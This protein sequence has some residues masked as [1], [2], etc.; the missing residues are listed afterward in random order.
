M[1]TPK[2][3]YW[4][5]LQQQLS[6]AG[7]NISVSPNMSQIV[8]GTIDD[9]M[10]MMSIYPKDDDGFRPFM[11]ISLFGQNE[12]TIIPKLSEFMGYKPF[13]KYLSKML[14]TATAT[15][16]WGKDAPERIAKIEADKEQ[17]YEII[18]LDEGFV[19]PNPPD[20]DIYFQQFTPEIVKSWED[21]VRRNPAAEWAGH[22]IAK[23]LPFIKKTLPRFG[24]TQSMF[25]LSIIS[26]ENKV[27]DV[28]K[29][30]RHGLEPLGNA[31]ILNQAEITNIVN[32]FTSTE[33]TWDSGN[34]QQFKAF[35][36]NGQEY[37]LQTDSYR[38]FRDLN[39]VAL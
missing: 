28:E 1:S 38:N 22:N 25:G 37:H 17:Y 7:L 6:A 32:W 23:L 15:Y 27:S 24:S 34:G 14:D 21:A 2:I 16:E 20:V 3:V 12:E 9:Q 39:L 36:I 19:K 18:K 31:E 30:V 29:I 35:S 11:I 33:P 26:I 13:C 10:F 8:N 5:E 4:A